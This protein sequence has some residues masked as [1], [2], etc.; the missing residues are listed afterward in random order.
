MIQTLQAV[1]I[2][3]AISGCDPDRVV[4]VKDLCHTSA[5]RGTATVTIARDFA[6]K[7]L[8][9]QFDFS[10]E[11]IGSVFPTKEKRWALLCHQRA[12]KRVQNKELATWYAAMVDAAWDAVPHLTPTP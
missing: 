10:Y 1:R 3:E 6:I 2:L 4:R 11:H 9:E 8:K 12:D 7:L 5:E